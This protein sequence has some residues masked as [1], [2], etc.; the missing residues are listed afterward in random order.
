MACPGGHPPAICSSRSQVPYCRGSCVLSQDIEGAL[1][2]LFKIS[3]RLHITQMADLCPGGGGDGEID[4]PLHGTNCPRGITTLAAFQCTK[5]GGQAGCVLQPALHAA[6]T[7][8]CACRPAQLF[9]QFLSANFN[10]TL[11]CSLNPEPVVSWDQT[12]VTTSLQKWRSLPCASSILLSVDLHRV[13]TLYISLK[14]CC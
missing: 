1:L 13:V 5:Q 11:S 9:S 14:G 4:V 7:T 10:H 3:T 8:A 6:L 12:C 2:T